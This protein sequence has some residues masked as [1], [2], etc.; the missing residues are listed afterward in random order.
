VPILHCSKDARRCQRSVEENVHAKSAVGKGANNRPGHDRSPLNLI[1]VEAY[2]T[3]D[4]CGEMAGETV[5]GR[6]GIKIADCWLDVCEIEPLERA[7]E[8]LG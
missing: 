6:S 8:A 5:S 2:C 7:A 3:R 1:F 4:Q